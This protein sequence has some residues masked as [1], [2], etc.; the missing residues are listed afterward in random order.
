MS[1]HVEADTPI[2]SESFSLVLRASRDT[3]VVLS[4]GQRL[5][6]VDIHLT[7]STKWRTAQALDR[8]LMIDDVGFL[9]HNEGERGAP[10]VHGGALLLNTTVV[11]SLLCAGTTGKVRLVLPTVPFEKAKDA[12]YVWGRSRPNMLRISHLE[13]S[14]L[15][16]EGMQSDG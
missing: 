15:G 2:A 8:D 14:V 12:P 1:L 13:V 6:D 5:A 3:N 9:A 16:G 11:A 7:L 4:T 10:F